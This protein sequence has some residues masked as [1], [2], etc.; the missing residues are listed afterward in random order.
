MN[1]YFIFQPDVI[2]E[3]TSVCDR[4]CVG[5][6]AP[7]F[8]TNQDSYSLFRA[9]PDLFLR[10]DGLSAALETIVALN[11]R[12]KTASVRGGEPTKHPFLPLL[13]HTLARFVD[14]IYLET[15]GHWILSDS[16]DTLNL[17]ESCKRNRATLKISF[18]KMHGLSP[19]KL[20]TIAQKLSNISN[21][22][23]IAITESSVGDFQQVR[24]HCDW[25]KDDQIIFQRKAFSADDL[26]QPKF[27]VIRVNGAL[28]EHL[29]TKPTFVLN[30]KE[31]VV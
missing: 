22:F 30:Q 18:D 5:C 4:K 9:N 29:T 12:I 17:L 21:R 25:L 28:S 13:L 1:S 7:N 19:E 26:I 11:G 6:Y 15:H 2:V 3:A 16:E 8:T 20:R 27:G 23:A 24:T 14:T 31:I 10:N